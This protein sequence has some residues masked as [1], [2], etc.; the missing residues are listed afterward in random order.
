[1]VHLKH[2]LE[3]LNALLFCVYTESSIFYIFMS[4]ILI[5]TVL[6]A[7]FVVVLWNRVY[8]LCTLYVLNGEDRG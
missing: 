8:N 5:Y 6:A 7:E 4:Y 3:R 1:M 2:W